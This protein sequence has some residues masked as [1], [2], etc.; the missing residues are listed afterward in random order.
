MND[1]SK[2][3]IDS[4]VQLPEEGLID[5]IFEPWMKLQIFSPTEYY[6]TIMELV[7]KRR[8]FLSIRIILHLTGY[9]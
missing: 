8:V 7:R 3:T 9:N 1:G 2:I 5:E 4:P 6:G